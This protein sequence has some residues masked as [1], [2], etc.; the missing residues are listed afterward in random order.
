[1]KR[2]LTDAQKDSPPEM[3]VSLM[4][5]LPP[6]LTKCIPQFVFQTINRDQHLYWMGYLTG[7][8]I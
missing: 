6:T 2:Y 7:F 5:V 8:A 1:M 4:S 3:A